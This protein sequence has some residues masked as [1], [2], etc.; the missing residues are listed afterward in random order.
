MASKVKKA[1]RQWRSNRRQ[2][3]DLI[4][5][6]IFNTNTGRATTA[7][8]NC[9]IDLD[10]V[11]SI[12]DPNV[13]LGNADMMHG[14]EEVV[15]MLDQ[16]VTRRSL[17]QSN[18]RCHSIMLSTENAGLQDFCTVKFP[19][20]K[21]I[22]SV[23]NTGK[24]GALL[25]QQQRN[26]MGDF[27]IGDPLALC[28]HLA[29]EEVTILVAVKGCEDEITWPLDKCKMKV[30][31]NDSTCL[32]ITH[33]RNMGV[34]KVSSHVDLK[35]QSVMDQRR[36]CGLVAGVME[37]KWHL[38]PVV[39]VRDEKYIPL[40]IWVGTFNQGSMP[41]PD[42]LAPWLPRSGYDI[43]VVGYQGCQ[44]D[45]WVEHLMQN[46]GDEMFP[47]AASHEAGI[48]TFAAVH[49][50]HVHAITFV[51]TSSRG[52]GVGGVGY[53][54]GAVSLKFTIYGTRL[55]FVNCHLAAHQDQIESRISDIK[56]ITGNTEFGMHYADIDFTNRNNCFW[57]GDLNFRLEGERDEI[58]EKIQEEDWAGLCVCPYAS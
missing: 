31:P 1:R 35:F 14:G 22:T 27:M 56:D 5:A 13:R 58:L 50:K 4:Q 19:G 51:E 49:K 26:D 17:A 41:P 2:C 25:P 11:N 47:I 54:K 21:I 32:T 45:E 6:A 42:K 8:T 30:W 57:F 3:I 10:V 33:R 55:A 12:E 28:L 36:F 16:L 9:M 40:S 53:N 29:D 23:Q 20:Y 48:K 15:E 24:L 44:E 37:H 46:L 38:P 7:W 34:A 18:L 39:R 52:T 43:V